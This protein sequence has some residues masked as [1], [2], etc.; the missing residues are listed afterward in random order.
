MRR[1]NQLERDLNAFCVSFNPDLLTPIRQSYR[2]ELEG[3]LL[4]PEHQYLL[5]GGKVFSQQIGPAPSAYFA[6]SYDTYPLLWFSNNDAP[7]FELFE[8]FFEALDLSEDLKQLV[9]YREQ[10]VMYCGFLVIGNRAPEPL[11]HYDYFPGANAYTLI[12]PLFELEPEHGQLLYQLGQ[13]VKIY[14]YQL[15]EA[16][17]LGEGFL[18]STQTYAPSQSLRV[19]VSMTFGTDK[20]RYW[21]TLKQNI[22]EQ[23]NYYRLP[24][25]H[26][27]GSCRCESS[28]L[29]R[30]AA[31][32]KSITSTRFAS[33]T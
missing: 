11:W 12:T 4:Q 30:W 2:R 25:G 19:L 21:E 32:L 17:L 24:C 22:E 27:V 10:I 1:L 23:S 16:I 18:H 20:W 26:I 5:E 28:R 6:C 8:D 15:G 9:D 29:H 33:Q 7:T 13:E 31:A 14:P 3:F